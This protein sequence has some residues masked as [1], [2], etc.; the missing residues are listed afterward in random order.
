MIF[1]IIV[2]TGIYVQ[3]NVFTNQLTFEHNLLK[4]ISTRIP[5]RNV[6]K[7]T[8]TVM[9]SLLFAAQAKTQSFMTS[10]YVSWSRI[11]QEEA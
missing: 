5:N 3:E 11:S 9:S 4:H 6:K 10:C 8:L 1:K 2:Y 7:R